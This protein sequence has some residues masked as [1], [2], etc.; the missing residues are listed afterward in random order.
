[1]WIAGIDRLKKGLW[2]N[3]YMSGAPSSELDL[4]YQYFKTLLPELVSKGKT[5]CY[6]LVHNKELTGVFAS[7]KEAYEAG[8]SKFGTSIFL[9]QLIAEEV[10]PE[11][12]QFLLHVHP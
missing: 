1:M 2:Y 9:V 6:A 10:R 7:E 11:S 3:G 5:G 4:E 8:V 12:I